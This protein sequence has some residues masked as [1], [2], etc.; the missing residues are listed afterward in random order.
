M[1]IIETERL[2]MREMEQSDLRALCRVL[3]DAEVMYAYEHAFPDEEVQD[4]LDRQIERYHRDGIGLWAAV[5]KETDEIIGQCGL[6]I[7]ECNGEDVVE[8]GYLFEKAYWHQGYASEAAIA[9]KEYA[10]DRLGID[11]VYSIIRDTNTA[12]QKV[13]MRNGM[14]KKGQMTKYYYGMT[15]P[16]YIYSSKRKNA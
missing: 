12:S 10:F 8:V 5:L 15:M 6:T 11:E 4:W 2:Y 14:T 13:A 1:K 7:Q 3:Q 9:C 16:H